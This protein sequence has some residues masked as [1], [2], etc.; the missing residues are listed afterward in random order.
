LE[1]FLASSLD[2]TLAHFGSADI[3]A[4]PVIKQAVKATEGA[5]AS[6]FDELHSFFFTGLEADGGSRRNIETQAVSGG[7]IEGERAI[8]FEEVVMAAHLNGTVAGVAH[9][10]A[11]RF[12]ADVR[13]DG[14]L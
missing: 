5:V 10:D 8:C 2:G 13:T 11:L 7:A 9:E 12:S 14:P 3:A 1:A 4:S 6:K